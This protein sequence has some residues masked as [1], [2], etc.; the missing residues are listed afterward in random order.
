MSL[1][2]KLG[3]V[4]ILI[5]GSISVASAAGS[6]T[7]TVTDLNSL[8]SDWTALTGALNAANGVV[9]HVAPELQA[10]AKSCADREKETQLLQDYWKRYV[11]GLK[12]EMK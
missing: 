8:A 11:A 4:S 2:L 5:A 1:P 10:L 9:A 7:A 12:K 3:V 6:K